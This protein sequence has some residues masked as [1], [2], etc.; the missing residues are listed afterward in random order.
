VS[1]TP[2]DHSKPWSVQW[3][4]RRSST[5]PWRWYTRYRPPLQPGQTRTQ[6]ASTLPTSAASASKEKH[7]WVV[8]R[9]MLNASA[10]VPRCRSRSVLV[11]LVLLELSGDAAMVVVGSRGRGHLR[12]LVLGS[13]AV[14]LVRHANCPV[15]VHRPDILS[16][17]RHGIAVGVDATQDSLK[18]LDFAFRQA[19]WHGLPLTVVHS[20]Y[21]THLSEDDG[22]HPE[23]NTEDRLALAESLAGFGQSYPDVKV[24]PVVEQGNAGTS[25]DGAR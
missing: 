25:P 7:Y 22:L 2:P 1:T 17:G 21:F 10:S 11:T 14:A 4:R 24:H 13:T 8:R 5:E 19:D 6:I 9:G 23:S 15:V 12:N 20:W 3:S 16:A 18:V